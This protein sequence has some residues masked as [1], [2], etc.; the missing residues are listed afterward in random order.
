M[1]FLISV[2]SHITKVRKNTVVDPV[3]CFYADVLCLPH[4]AIDGAMAVLLKDNLRS[5]SEE[6]P[7]TEDGTAITSDLTVASGSAASPSANSAK[8][9]SLLKTIEELRGVNL[10]KEKLIEVQTKQAEQELKSKQCRLNMRALAK[11]F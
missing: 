9:D 8:I 6:T 4:P 3:V 5:N 11:E 7:G 10:Q 2:A 1:T